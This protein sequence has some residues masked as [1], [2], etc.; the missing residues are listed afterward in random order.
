VDDEVCE[1]LGKISANTDNWNLD[2][3]NEPTME[4]RVQIFSVADKFKDVSE[5]FN[6]DRNVILEVSKDFDEHVALPK[7]E[8]ISYEPSKLL[9]LYMWFLL[10]LKLLQH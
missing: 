1:L 2:K 4:F 9:N 7:E 10:L 6:L 8:F 3:G 5:R